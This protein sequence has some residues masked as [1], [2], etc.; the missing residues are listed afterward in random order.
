MAQSVGRD[1]ALLFHYRSTRNNDNDDDDNNNNNNNTLPPQKKTM[2]K[3]MIEDTSSFSIIS[4]CCEIR[5]ITVNDQ[6][7]T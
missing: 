5:R 3:D 4:K 6:H 1:I 7:N 2:L